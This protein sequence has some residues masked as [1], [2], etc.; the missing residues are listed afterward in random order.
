[1]QQPQPSS[2]ISC[3]GEDGV[4]SGLRSNPLFSAQRPSVCACAVCDWLETR[5]KVNKWNAFRFLTRRIF[6][7]TAATATATATAASA[8]SPKP[9]PTSQAIT[10]SSIQ[11][12]FL[13]LLPLVRF[14]RHKPITS[15]LIDDP[16]SRTLHCLVSFPF[17][18][19]ILL[20]Q[21]SAPPGTRA[22]W[23][24]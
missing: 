6:W 22:I 20:I 4:S 2:D 24:S 1:M 11:H 19:P 10:E 3:V 18:C 15:L 21:A 17:F 12:F 13:S 23:I 5:Q 16:R 9:P 14:H 7:A 8:Y